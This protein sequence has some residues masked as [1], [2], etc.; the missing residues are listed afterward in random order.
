M[1]GAGDPS[2][3]H[4]MV[5]SFPSRAVRFAGGWIRMGTEAESI[6]NVKSNN[7]ISQ[8]FNINVCFNRIQIFFM[9]VTNMGFYIG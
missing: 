8:Q 4:E 6:L 7:L 3:V 9:T 5:A 1:L 2:A